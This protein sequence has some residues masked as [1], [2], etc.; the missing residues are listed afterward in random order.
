[1]RY[2]LI[3][4][5]TLERAFLASGLV[6][7]AMT[8]EYGPAY[9]RAI[10]VA[11]ER[12]MFDALAAGPLPTEAIAVASGTDVRATE[13]VLNLLVTMRYLK[14]RDGEYRLERHVRRWLLADVPGSIRDAV[15]MKRLEWRWI[16]RLDTFIQD[17]L[18]LDV[19]ESM[20]AEEWGLYQRG[21]RAQAN[22]LAPLLG[23]AI[24]VP[25]GARSMLDIGGSHGYFSVVLC[26]RHPG[27][28]ATVL[29][30]PGAVEHAAP[31][32]AQEGMGDRVVLQAGNALTD[33]LGESVHDL[34]LMFS[35]VH[36]FDDGTNRRLIAKSARALR[37]GGALVIGEVLRPASPGRGGQLGAFFDLYFSLISRSGTWTLA[38]MRSWQ[39]AAG[40]VPR[41]P[42]RLRFARGVGL[43]VADR[44]S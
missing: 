22:V 44:A 2:G 33:D 14:V 26:R 21:M 15:L 13:K 16:E 41:K 29:D 34:I 37:P 5:N 28:H 20:T 11:T 39:I 7:T 30:L 31:L 6:P 8:E 36:H 32:L 4:E 38:E 42:M 40:L 35:L 17:G 10:M 25:A 24:P 12:G 43:Q 9:A 1:M 27:L 3:A 18:A 23:R 19:H